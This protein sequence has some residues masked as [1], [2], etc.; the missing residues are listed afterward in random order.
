MRAV[1]AQVI[2]E[3][4]HAFQAPRLLRS[5]AVIALSVAV[6]SAACQ[7]RCAG[8]GLVTGR[9][10]PTA[11][12]GQAETDAT[13]TF[14]A[15]VHRI[16]V[17]YND[18]TTSSSTIQYGPTSRKVLKGATLM[19]WSYSEDRGAT[20][21]YGGKVAPP[22]GWSVLWGD[23]AMTTSRRNYGRAFMSSLAFP[24]A[25]FPA[26]GV[27]GPV[28][29]AVGGACIARSTDGGVTFQNFQCLTNR[30]P[31]PGRPD[32]VKGHFYD[33]GSMAAG[34]QGEIYASFVDVDTS[35]LDI[36]VSP[37]GNQP[38]TPMPT[39]FPNYYVGSHPRIRVAQDG[40]LFVMA[41]IKQTGSNT[42]ILAASRFRNGAWQVPTFVMSFVAAY[43][44]VPLGSTVLGS[45]LNVRTGPQ[46]S[47]DIGA[48]SADR[49]DRIRFLAT[50]Y[51]NRQWLFIRGGI[52]DF[53]LKSCGW[54]DG[55]TFGVANPG[56][57]DTQRLDVFNPNVVA[58][59]GFIG[60]APRWQGT[61]LSR[62]GNSTTTLNLTRGTLGYVNGSP[63]AIPFDIA[64]NSPVCSDT[65]GYWGDYD[66]FLSVQVD[67]DRLRFMRFTTD[68]SLGC[69]S[70]W[71]FVGRQQHVRAVDYWY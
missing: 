36:W 65:R 49:D 56:D 3:A 4:V 47:F 54:Y 20:W 16:I 68:S 71:T 45:P 33:G 44:E 64:Q 7:G 9:D 51:N 69:S 48:S 8:V 58:F 12:A 21:K 57:R 15:G 32:A 38:F 63:L 40:T 46:F 62:F 53:D 59:P 25:K 14:Q 41:I 34:P 60:I 6:I 50:Q 35:Q 22:A 39:P 28:N 70:R 29:S 30:A 11:E 66:G 24:D 61:F 18:E 13:T 19:G 31:V 27:D 37:D 5:R 67:G 1:S 52:C 10:G 55:W 43:P 23:P 42:Y 17:A 26:G 2:V